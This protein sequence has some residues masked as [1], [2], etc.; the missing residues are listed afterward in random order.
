MSNELFI[1]IFDV[2]HGACA[3]IGAVTGRLAMIDSG[4]NT[5]TG[6]R[7]STYIRYELNRSDLDFLFVTNADQDHLSD[8]EGLWEHGIKVTTLYRNK[9]PNP[10][11]L[12]KIKQLQCE[13]TD[14][15]ERYLRIHADY[16]APA[17][18]IFDKEM[19]GATC[20]TFCNSYP[21]FDDTNN[22]SLVVFIKYGPFKMLFPGDLEEAGWKKLLENNSFIEE[23]SGTTVLV[24]SH[25]GRES[26]FCQDIFDHFTPQAVVISDKP[27]S[28]ATQEI[29]PVYRAM[30]NPTGVSVAN[31]PNRRHVLTTRRDGDILF[32]I[33]PDG[34]FRIDTKWS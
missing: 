29:V 28:H 10:I 31:Q 20:T 21:E 3:M 5:T 18:F 12:S 33:S 9:S 32:S 7:P 1:R 14:D 4:H 2:E 19:G 16:N 23:L 17:N 13:L 8:L 6:W 24:A 34:S 11:I 15:V 26:G 27:I 25:H 30:V 22:L